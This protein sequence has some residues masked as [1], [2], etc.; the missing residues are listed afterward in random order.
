MSREWFSSL[1]VQGIIL[2][3]GTGAAFFKT[4]EFT[5]MGMCMTWCSRPDSGEE[6]FGESYDGWREE[7]CDG[8]D[9]Q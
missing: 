4:S 2:S 5:W 8:G 6:T 1:D 3:L 7:P 9:P